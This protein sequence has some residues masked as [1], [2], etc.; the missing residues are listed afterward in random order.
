M[1]VPQLSTHSLLEAKHFL[2]RGVPESNLLKPPLSP[3][4]LQATRLC[5]NSNGTFTFASGTSL[6]HVRCD[7]NRKRQHPDSGFDQTGNGTQQNDDEEFQ[8][9]A[10]ADDFLVP[11]HRFSSL[12]ISCDSVHSTHE[13]EVQSISNSKHGLMA[14][15]DSYGRCIITHISTEDQNGRLHGRE[16]FYTLSPAGRYDGIPSWAGVSFLCDPVESGSG[17]E[18]HVVVAREMFRDISLFDGELNVRTLHTTQTP[19]AL[20]CISSNTIALAERGDIC[21]YDIRSNK[22][23]PSFRKQISQHANSSLYCL[24]INATG[25]D[26]VTAGAERVVHVLDLRAGLSVRDRWTGCLKHECAGIVLSS[27]QTTKGGRLGVDQGLDSGLAYVCSTDNEVACGAINADMANLVIESN[28][29]ANTQKMM[30]GANARSARRAFGF[31]ADLRVIGMARR[32]IDGIEDVAVVTES[33]G[34]YLLR[35]VHGTT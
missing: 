30:S 15:V 20:K 14:S 24:D 7:P 23:G 13:T 2:Y 19:Q 18:N 22:R 16:Q 21:L 32:Y 10:V 26:I 12:S 4:S 29:G 8:N 1:P 35:N 25:T 9:G 3:A 33:M 31:R 34:F 17:S 5:S 28:G 11:S 6:F 27:T